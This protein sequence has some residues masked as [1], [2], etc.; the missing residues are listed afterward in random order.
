MGCRCRGRCRCVWCRVCVV[1]CGVVWCG[2]VC[3]V[4]LWCGVLCGVVWCVVW[5]GVVWCGVVCGVVWCGVVCVCVV[6]TCLVFMRCFSTTCCVAMPA[7]SRPGI[8]STACPCM[9]CQRANA[10]CESEQ[11][12]DRSVARQQRNTQKISIRPPALT[13]CGV[14]RRSAECGVRSA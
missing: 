14:V 8:H 3:C 9:R 12:T 1:W 7:W 5:C 13:E 11:T 2:V 10:S 6:S 4:V